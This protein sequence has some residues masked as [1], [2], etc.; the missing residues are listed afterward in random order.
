MHF[1]IGPR[2]NNSHYTIVDNTFTKQG[3]RFI[4]KPKQ[5][6]VPQ[7]NMRPSQASPNLLMIR[8]PRLANLKESS[9]T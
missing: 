5:D 6:A 2:P 7:R 8:A 3:G 1:Q 9:P 4:Q